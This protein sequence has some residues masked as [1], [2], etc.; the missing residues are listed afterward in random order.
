VVRNPKLFAGTPFDLEVPTHTGLQTLHLVTGVTAVNTEWLLELAPTLF[1]NRKGRVLYDPR[2]GCLAERQQIRF[3]KRVLEGQSS[4]LLEDTR[5]TRC[6]A[7]DSA[8]LS[9]RYSRALME[10]YRLTS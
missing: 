6:R 1:A 3:G 4:P 2:L 5:Q 8:R 10:L 7:L 9:K